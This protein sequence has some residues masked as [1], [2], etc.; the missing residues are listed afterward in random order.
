MAESEELRHLEQLIE[1]EIFSEVLHEAER[2]EK[3]YT[4]T[5][6]H[7]QLADVLIAKVKALR[8]LGRLEES[9]KAIKQCEH[10]LTFLEQPEEVKKRE[11]HLVRHKGNI[12]FQKH[13][14]KRGLKYYQ[15]SLAINEEIGYKE[16][17]LTSLTNLAAI[18]IDL[19][20]LKLALK[21][22]NQGKTLSEEIGDK[23][24]IANSL[25]CLGYTYFVMNDLDQAKN[26]FHQ[27]GVINGLI[28]AEL[29]AWYINFS[30]PIQMTFQTEFILIWTFISL[31][32]TVT[33]SEITTRRTMNTII[34][35]AL[36]G[37]SL[38]NIKT[39][40]SLYREWGTFL[41]SRDKRESVLDKISL[42]P[43]DKKKG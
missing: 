30:I 23:N 39:K 13:D 25:L 40:K 21:Y 33:T 36:S 22:R 11:A 38:F 8:A 6:K 35:D 41:E 42:D 15:Q 28:G 26:L 20:D 19:S 3:R 27:G 14:L 32:I 5:G 2:L 17:I 31:L 12:Y 7:Q 10:V 18:Y 29:I 9:L 34:A 16:G 37:E 24:S 1:Q 43:K 4:E